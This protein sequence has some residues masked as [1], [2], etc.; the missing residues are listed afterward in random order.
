MA[1]ATGVSVPARFLFGW[2]SDRVSPQYLMGFAALL[3]VVG[4]FVLEACVIKLGWSGYR[5][6][7]LFALFQG[8]GVGGCATTMPVLTGRCFGAR[9]FGKI[10]GLVM[11]GFAIGNILTP[12][13]GIIYDKTGSYEMAFFI[14][15]GCAALGIVLA[16]LI[17]P[18]ALQPEFTTED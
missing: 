18:N 5:P 8:C 13:A 12:T 15:M 4:V 17:R 6:I 3:L 11:F 10:I 1:F 14:C 9:N 2:L 16:L 7:V